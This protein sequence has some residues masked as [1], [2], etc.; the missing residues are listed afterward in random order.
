M[1]ENESVRSSY[2]QSTSVWSD[3]PLSSLH[4]PLLV[5][6]QGPDLYDVA[7]NLVVQNL[8]GL[9]D[10][11]PSGEQLNH[12][13]GLENDVW[14]ESLA[15]RAHRHRAVDQV[16]GTSDALEKCEVRYLVNGF[17]ERNRLSHGHPA[18][19]L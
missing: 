6:D 13:P 15:S 19:A 14:V 7:S 9:G 1:E 8:H 2:F 10:G 16:K 12:V 5:S 17:L 18:L 3:D 4:E 11:D